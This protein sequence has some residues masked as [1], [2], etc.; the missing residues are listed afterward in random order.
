M[1]Q[2]KNIS[3]ETLELIESVDTIAPG[4]RILV[5]PFGSIKIEPGETIIMHGYEPGVRRVIRPVIDPHVPRDGMDA[6]AQ[7]YAEKSSADF[8]SGFGEQGYF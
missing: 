5:S 2:I 7:T 1:I 8:D 3:N 6:Q 4:C